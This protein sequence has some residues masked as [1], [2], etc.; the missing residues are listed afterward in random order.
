MMKSS[1]L[2]VALAGVLAFCS[3]G[4]AIAQKSGGTLRVQHR[5]NP[6][7]LSIH[8]ESSVSIQQPAMPSMTMPLASGSTNS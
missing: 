3:I 4:P 8:E 5:D 1:T 7:S 2:A 6:A